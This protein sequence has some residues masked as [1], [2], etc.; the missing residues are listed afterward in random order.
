MSRGG[1]N[2]LGKYLDL[3]GR[4]ILDH[5]FAN[6][7]VLYRLAFGRKNPPPENRIFPCP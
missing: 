4:C 1:L 3:V 6:M 2:L 7:P 5:I